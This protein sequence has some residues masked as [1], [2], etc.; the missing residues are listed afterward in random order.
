LSK[1]RIIVLVAPV[2]FFALLA[3]APETPPGSGQ[4]VA[5]A[6]A[7]IGAGDFASA[8][9]SLEKVVAREPSN[10]LAWR[11]L[12]FAYLKQKRY[13]DARAAYAKLLALVPDAPQALYNT[14][15]SYALEGNRDAAF[16]WLGRAKATR[17]LDMTQIQVDE[18]LAGLKS[19][20][21]FAALLPRPEDF[22][23]PFVESEHVRVL[24]EWDGEGQGDQFG[25]IAR[26]LGD[27][28][29]DGVADFVASAPTWSPGGGRGKDAG[30]V[31]VYSTK[32]GK[33]LWKADGAP[34]DELGTGVELAGDTNGDGVPDVVAGAP[35]NGK[36]Y[37]YSGRDGRI[38]LT[39]AADAKGDVFGRHVSTA[40]DVDGDGDDDVLIGAPG[41]AAGGKD[42]GRAYLYSGKDGKRLMTWSGERAGD[43]FGSTVAGFTPAK[44]KGQVPG[45]G[46]LLLIG[47]PGAGPR[48][49]G[50]VY[51]YGGLAAKPRL[52]LESDDTGAAFGYMFLSIPG[53]LDG[54]GVPD[55]YATDFTNSAR[56]PS[57]GRAYVFS[58]KTGKSLL[59]LTGE[60]ASE[61]FGIGPATAG[62]ADGDGVPDL[63]VGAWQ[64]A[65]AA[66]SGGRAYLHS[67]RDGRLLKT[68]TC[69]T[70]G[71]T[72]GFDAVGLGDTDGDGTI[73]FL[74]TSA[75]SGVK[76]NHS[77]RVFVISSGVKKGS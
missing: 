26:S 39:L 14:G 18:D 74:I 67:G 47:A 38:L 20:P 41:N 28:D 71:D 45:Q 16:E 58:G 42:A 72:F 60:G 9:A 30:R 56:G 4:E 5:A 46:S 59:T 40:G 54:D 23:S 70:P 21:R 43:Q 35:G 49:T 76:G 52:V 12:G 22:A 50:R 44:G 48:K 33:L 61:G 10:K 64:Y 19:D 37:V 69:R 11:Y 15:V 3:G 1:N 27:V 68:Y 77:G 8:S 6:A 63:I 66:V 17:R 13:A 7:K 32:T 55:L 53:D 29:G 25:W 65:G 31:Y 62:D 57:T 34:A 73:D 2:V 24:R 36:A 75:W 51:V